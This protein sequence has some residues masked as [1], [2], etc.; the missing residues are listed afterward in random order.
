MNGVRFAKIGRCIDT[1]V[2]L[3]LLARLAFVMPRNW[4]IRH[5]NLY[6]PKEFYQGSSVGITVC[7]P[8]KVFVH[9]CLLA[10]QRVGYCYDPVSV[11]LSAQNTEV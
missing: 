10:V 1:K 3:L 5:P 7:G 9:P 11:C 8:P 2:M 6:Q 4:E